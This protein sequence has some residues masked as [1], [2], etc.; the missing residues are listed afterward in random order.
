[1][2]V[3]EFQVRNVRSLEGVS[4]KDLEDT[5][6][7]IGEN[8]SG[9]TNIFEALWWFFT[10]FSYNAES[11][12]RTLTDEDYYLWFKGSTEEPIKFKAVLELNK[13]EAEE[14]WKVT[15]GKEAEVKGK[16]KI[17]ENQALKVKRSLVRKNEGVY[18]RNDLIQWGS[19]CL[20][21]EE[22]E[23]GNSK[24]TS[25]EEVGFDLNSFAQT[26]DRLIKE[27]FTYIPL[28][29]IAKLE[30][31]HGIILD[32]ALKDEIV[33]RGTD[34][35]APGTRRWSD[36]IRKRKTLIPEQVEI[37]GES[38]VLYKGEEGIPLLY[39]LE[40][41][42]YQAC[43]NIIEQVEKGG[44]IV[45]IEEPENHLHPKLQK[46]LLKELEKQVDDKKQIFV[47]THS[48]FLIDHINLKRVWFI[49]NEGLESNVENISSQKELS[50]AL[51]EIG[52]RPSDLLFANGVLVVEGRDDKE[53]LSNWARKMEKSFEDIN[54]LVIDA[55][56]F[57]NIKKYL[58]SEVIKRTTF[59]R[60]CIFDKNPEEKIKKLREEIEKEQL[61]PEKND[62]SLEKGDL[63]DY[64]PREIVNDFV[65]EMAKKKGKEEEIPDKI[66]VGETVQI[67][68][69]ILEGK[70]WKRYLAKRVIEK[71]K[72]EDIQEEI[73]E[74]ILRIH[75]S[76]KE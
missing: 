26:V 56:G 44:D 69:G 46:L 49:W 62:L 31:H 23:Y 75:N 48:P 8:S 38:I 51:W 53:V 33:N 55:E 6:I 10:Q 70:W 14:L 35:S 73:K 3:R 19:I 67:L 65:R 27:N 50:E 18:C 72:L 76:L 32:P 12:L 54:L 25:K 24:F 28:G 66:E 45:V 71:A 22:T 41:G 52:V 39:E 13:K 64:Y 20:E 16:E 47:A 60:F 17:E 40:G 34:S 29:R 21:R 36:W 5:V 74:K 37:K 7:L 61:I 63:E 1:M 59:Q 42:G 11:F 43:L 68:D 9:K 4:L 15:K 30:K 58:K 2:K 57:R